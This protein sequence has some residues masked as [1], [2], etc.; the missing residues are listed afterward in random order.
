MLTYRRPHIIRSV[1]S[2][3]ELNK[4][5]V[6]LFVEAVWNQGHLELIDELVAADYIGRIPCLPSGILGPPGVRELISSHRRAYPNLHLKIED[7]IAE[8]DLVVMRWQ[9]TAAPPEAKGARSSPGDAQCYEGI[10]IIRLLAGKQVDTHTEL[11]KLHPASG[12]PA[13]ATH[14]DRADSLSAAETNP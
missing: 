4:N 11:H 8:E 10:S 5:R 2:V 12:Q 6:R 14:L 9:A 1:N 3:T 7:Q 13:R